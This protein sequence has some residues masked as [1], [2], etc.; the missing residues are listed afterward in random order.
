MT[1]G[2]NLFNLCLVPTYLVRGGVQEVHSNENVNSY[3]MSNPLDCA[4]LMIA[5][6]GR[7]MSEK[8]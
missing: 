1:Q 4:D 2:A 7:N 8:V 6:S 3:N 5:Q